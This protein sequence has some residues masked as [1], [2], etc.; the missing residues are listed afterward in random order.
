VYAG[1]VVSGVALRLLGMAQNFLSCDRE[2]ELLLPPSLRDWLGED[3][4]VW[5]VLD[6]VEMIDLDECYGAYRAD[7]HGRAAHDP[8]MMVALLL[9]SYAAGERSSRA[10]ERRCREDVPTR[11]ICANRVPDH[12]TIARFRA[13]HEVALSR[14]FTQILG[15]CAKAGLVSVGV[16]ALDGTAVAADASRAVTRTHESI[17]EE[18]EQ[19]L[20]DAAA[21]D[22]AEDEQHGDARGD[23]LPAE[24]VDRRSRLARLRR[25]RE[26]LEAE[27][28]KTVAAY[29]ENLRWRAEWEAEH[30]R[31][32]GG[33]KPFAPDPDGLSK[34]TINT[35][36][37]DSR[38]I[39]RTGRV[40]IQGY[41]AQAVATAR[42]ILVAA[43]IT[44]QSNDSGQLEPMV[45]QA[46][47]TLKDAGVETP[48]G[49]VLA[50]GG[51][52]NS[53]QITALGQDSITAIV[54]TKAA[55]RAKARKLSSKQGLEAER[56][57]ALLETSEGAALYRRRQQMIE[58]VF[59]NTKFIRGI[60]RFHRRGLSACRAEWRLI[61]ATHNLLKLY[62]AEIATQTA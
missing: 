47:T 18:V 8:A 19:I 33:R 26:E 43:D 29:E 27:Q 9:Y 53:R 17:R 57:D 11:V 2:Q 5:F 54:P 35:T 45:R 62:R 49:T 50:D 1:F 32:L 55:H 46:L 61:A 60:T 48:I 16:V 52:W 36:D 20:G 3:H 56:I 23:E 51:Y 34:R 41:N 25:C 4:V 22:A 15:L 31:K 44:Q 13:R 6:A 42:Q 28:A 40:P 37:P 58:P 21:V 39:A 7:G 59:A 30:G 38:I 10:I 24:L 12:T 14:T